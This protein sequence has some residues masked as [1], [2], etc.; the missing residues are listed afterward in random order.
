MQYFELALG[1]PDGFQRNKFYPVTEKDEVIRVRQELAGLPF[2]ATEDVYLS[3]FDYDFPSTPNTMSSFEEAP[4]YG[5][6]YMDFDCA[7]HSVDKQNQLKWEVDNVI[8]YL[9]ELGVERHHV[10][11]YHSGNKGY[12]VIVPSEYVE[13]TDS[14]T[15]HRTFKQ[16]ALV[17]RRKLGLEFLDT[18]VYDS[19]RVLRLDKTYNVKGKLLKAQIAGGLGPFTDLPTEPVLFTDMALEASTSPVAASQPVRKELEPF[20]LRLLNKNPPQGQRQSTCYTISLYL[21][22]HGYSADEAQALLDNSPIDIESDRKRSAVQSAY[23]GDKH[24]GTKDN[25][26][27]TSAMSEEERIKSGVDPYLSMLVPWGKVLDNTKKQLTENESK[28][29]LSFGIETLD[30]YL[31]MI[32]PGELITIGGVSGIGKSEFVWNAAK[33]NAKAGVPVAFIGLEMGPEMY[34]MRTLRN[35]LGLDA[36]KFKTLTLSDEERASVDKELELMQEEDLPIHFFNPKF[37]LDIARLDKIVGEGIDKLGIRLWV[38]DHL[39]YFP[40]T[41]SGD[42]VTHQVST[43]VHGLKQLTLK[44]DVPILLVA[45]YRKIDSGVRASLNSFK[46]SI[47]IPQVSD[48]VLA[49]SRDT[50]SNSLAVQQRVEISVLK[51]RYGMSLAHF[52]ADFDPK[53]GTY[54]SSSDFSYGLKG[55]LFD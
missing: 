32:Q 7:D 24:F 47:A 16:L 11:V 42:D 43:I 22:D 48:T 29:L 51:S 30:N 23:S 14:R 25:D 18:V 15:R 27:A 4:K 36:S 10:R 40:A 12:H 49:L 46:D 6:F 45:H 34:T 1:T 33:A 9:V 21:K 2:G 55:E 3:V 13:V 19:R 44:Y 20:M 38:V 5:D 17:L 53:L 35:R 8:E 31:G 54:K 39:H 52:Y 37:K 26:I 50:T 41:S 28:G